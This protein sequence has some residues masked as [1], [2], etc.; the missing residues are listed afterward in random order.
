MKPQA[1]GGRQQ[2]GR[3]SSFRVDQAG[4]ASHRVGCVCHKRI[5]ASVLVACSKLARR[6]E[7]ASLCTGTDIPAGGI[8]GIAF[9]MAVGCTNCP[10]LDCITYEHLHNML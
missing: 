10:L 4:D 9:A 7:V 5:F 3:F 1:L 8:G 6:S 2:D